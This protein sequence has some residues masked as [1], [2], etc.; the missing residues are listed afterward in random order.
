MTLVPVGVALAGVARVVT[1]AGRGMV[2]GARIV[3]PLALALIGVARAAGP[4]PDLGV[5]GGGARTEGFAQVLEPREFAFP[6]D[7]GPHPEY[8]QEWWYV[9]GNL[10]SATGERFGFELTFFR[11]GLAPRVSESGPAPQGDESHW[12]S[13]Q[14]YMAHFAITDV[15]RKQFRFAQKLSRGA[16]GLAGA[17]AP[18]LRVWVDDWSLGAVA[19]EPVATTRAPVG[20]APAAAVAPMGGAAAGTD[21]AADTHWAL[22]AAQNGYE[23]SLDVGALL[24][25][26]LNGDRGLSRKSSE[27]GSASYYYSIPRVAVKG[28]LVRD[29]QALDVKGLAWVDREWG[30]GTLSKSEQGWDWFALQLRDGSALMFYA[31]RTRGGGRDPNS[32]GTWV[33]PSGQ[34]RALSTEQV[35]IDV[36]DYWANPRGERYP[37]RWRVR[38]PSVGVDVEVRPVLANQELTTLTRYWEGAVDVDR[39]GRRSRARGTQHCRQRCGGRRSRRL[40]GPGRETARR[41]MPRGAAMS[42][43]SGTRRNKSSGA[44]VNC[45]R[46]LIRQAFAASDE[47]TSLPDVALGTGSGACGCSRQRCLVG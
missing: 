8:R 27:L 47:W 10:D 44:P 31:L 38:V 3:A 4:L 35:Q 5:L 19:G 2:G 20:T 36:L 29:G 39:S 1:V 23:L 46:A 32:A 40:R 34:S 15:G 24:T 42:N 14:I 21:G 43:S 12:R 26:V 45:E 7:H 17:E 11:F 33:S 18:P 9:T 37:S 28:R 41:A 30:S 25:P 22:R 13:R 16:V 6:R